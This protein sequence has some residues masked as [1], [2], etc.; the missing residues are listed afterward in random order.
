MQEQE[1]KNGEN[2]SEEDSWWRRLGKSLVGPPRSRHEL[3][4]LLRETQQTDL[5][6]TD[7][8]WMLEGVLA[9]SETHVRDIMVPRSHMTVVE[10]HARPAG[11]L[12]AMVDSGHSRFPVIG[13]SRD[14][15]VGLLLAKDLLRFT[16]ENPDVPLMQHDC[17]VGEILR[18]VVFVPESKR[19]DI[20][21]KEFRSN[22]NHMAVVVD[23]YGGVAGLV[24]IEDVLEQIVG[25]IDDE[26]DRAAGIN[27]L[28]QDDRRY[29]V[30]GLT[31]I[32]EFNEF[33]GSEF[34]DDEFDTVAGLAMH[35]FGHMPERGEEVTLERWLFT[36]YH[37]DNRRI[38][39][40]LVTESA[41][42]ASGKEAS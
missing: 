13:G 27:I 3:I 20:L 10:R 17:D 41:P 5:V 1:E 18:P 38:Q 24:T 7:A 29:L 35:A 14:E 23:E 40:F 21:L 30:K 26:Y 11:V 37:C 33:F 25:E 39:Q 2:E 19:L 15:V 32:T 16:L 42:Q 12:E 4:E 36:V 22:R 34:S 31:P 8:L 28:R 9:T 6:N